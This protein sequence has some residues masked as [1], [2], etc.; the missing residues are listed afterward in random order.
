MNDRT[1]KALANYRKNA[2]RKSLRATSRLERLSNESG[3]E[4]SKRANRKARHTKKASLRKMNAEIQHFGIGV[5]QQV[6]A[7]RLA[8]AEKGEE[9]AENGN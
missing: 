1:Q 2:I 4:Q 8:L 6:K 9:V 3:A 7:A 5:Y